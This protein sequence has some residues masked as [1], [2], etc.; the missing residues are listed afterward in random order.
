MSERSIKKLCVL[1]IPDDILAEIISENK[2]RIIL[3]KKGRII[4]ENKVE[5]FKENKVKIIF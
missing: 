3:V 1:F 4:W 5:I 2:V